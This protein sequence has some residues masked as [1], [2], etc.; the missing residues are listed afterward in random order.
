MAHCRLL[1]GIQTTI[2]IFICA[3]AA[4]DGKTSWPLLNPL[5]SFNGPNFL[6]LR[7]CMSEGFFVDNSLS[8][9]IMPQHYLKIEHLEIGNTYYGYLN[10]RTMCHLQEET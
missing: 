3:L 1:S 9:K 8:T 10:S 6:M 4:G 5:N 7:R 2:H